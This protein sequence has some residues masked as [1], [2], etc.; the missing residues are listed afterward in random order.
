MNSVSSMPDIELREAIASE[1][2]PRRWEDIRINDAGRLVA[3]M[4]GILSEFPVEIPNWTS[5]R[6]DAIWLEGQIRK[7]GLGNA[8]KVALNKI[9]SRGQS[10]SPRQISEAGLMALRMNACVA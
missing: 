7:G 8:Y 2:A 1:L 5:N 3:D 9:V 10:P 4:V 6:K